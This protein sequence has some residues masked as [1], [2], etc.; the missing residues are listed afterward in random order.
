MD[1]T[2]TVLC[3]PPPPRASG[4]TEFCPTNKIGCATFLAFDWFIHIHTRRVLFQKACVYVC[5]SE[6]GGGGG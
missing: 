3:P 4:L 2:C 1:D 6:E 5:V